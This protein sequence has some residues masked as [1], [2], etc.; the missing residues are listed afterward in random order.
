[1]SLSV[2]VSSFLS[3]RGSSRSWPA[4]SIPTS[5]DLCRDGNAGGRRTAAE[6]LRGPAGVGCGERA[7]LPAGV[8]RGSLRPNLGQGT[9]SALR[10]CGRTGFLSLVKSLSS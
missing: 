2:P 4:P 5:R 8:S 3:R 1:M 6:T 7:H 10:A 9:R